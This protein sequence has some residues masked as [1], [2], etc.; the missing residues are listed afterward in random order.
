MHTTEILNADLAMKMVRALKRSVLF[1][2]LDDD[3]LEKVAARSQLVRVDKGERVVEEGKISDALFVILDGEAKV[4]VENSGEQVEVGRLRAPESFGEMGLLLSD[5]RTATVV[6]DTRMMLSRIDAK[7]FQAAFLRVP[8]FGLAVCQSLASR[9]AETSH[10]VPV[11]AATETVPPPADVIELLPLVFIQ[12]Q[13]VLPLDV[14][15]NRLRIGVVDDV[16]PAVMKQ[17]RALA[18]GM[19]IDAVSISAGFFNEVLSGHGQSVSRASESAAMTRFPSAAPTSLDPLLE[20]MVAEGASD[21]H[22]S[23]R[24]RPRWRID[25]HMVELRDAARLGADEVLELLGPVMSD[26]QRAK[27]AD[28]NDLD[29]AHAV[30][31]LARFRVNLFRDHRGVCAVLRTIPA[32]ILSAEKLGLPSVVLELTKAPKGLVLVTGPT[33]SGKSTTL[34]AMIDYINRTRRDHIITLEDPIEFVHE[35]QKC[36]VNQREIGPHTKSFARALKSALR[37]DPD[38]VLVG[39]MRDLE[40]VS[41]AMETANTGHLVFGT[42][43]TSTAVST[44]DRIVDMFPPEQQS[45]VRTAL[46]ESLRGVVAQTLCRRKGGGRVAALEVLVVNS[47]VSN[48]IRTGKTSQIASIMQTGRNQGMSVL[49]AELAELVKSGTVAF[50][51]AYAKAV[52]KRELCARCGVTP[53]T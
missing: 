3:K 7:T 36:L 8:G 33:G 50:E 31:G 39:E 28:E 14:Q 47:A 35:S 24:H 46:S 5:P 1:R 19:E 21:L 22:L 41:L 16:S 2:G 52:D 30:P 51:E 20:R 25:G 4:F 18:P 15:G 12:R 29:F 43:H 9:L 32:T 11:A 37:E 49:N 53:P 40:T 10:K 34:A 13:R 42:L 6:A 45:Q 17:V 26:A 48:L 38:I 23:A 27:F 44:V